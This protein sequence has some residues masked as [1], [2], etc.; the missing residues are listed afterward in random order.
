MPSR[1]DAIRMTPAEVDAYLH[2][3]HQVLNVASIGADDNIHMV[4]MWYG[5]VGDDLAF[6]TYNKSQKILNWSRNPRFTALVE[7]G[8]Q[9]SELRG[10]ELVG[11]VEL[12][13]VEHLD[14][15]S[16]R[17]LALPEEEELMRAGAPVSLGWPGEKPHHETRFHFGRP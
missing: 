7:S 2:E 11:T 10:V 16:Y 17:Y 12:S 9:Y 6:H 1:R 15:T 8:D 5:F 13:H 3:H 4:A 14:K